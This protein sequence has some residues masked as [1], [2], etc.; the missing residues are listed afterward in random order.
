MDY[1][2]LLAD[3]D[4]EYGHQK[5]I[6]LG[7]AGDASQ[8]LPDAQREPVHSFWAAR[9]QRKKDRL[10]SE[11]SPRSFSKVATD[12]TNAVGRGGQLL[13]PVKQEERTKMEVAM[14]TVPLPPTPARP[15][16]C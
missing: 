4:Y 11:R 6:A 1:S 7:A 13:M 3:S 5:P 10:R 15:S 14:M 8:V 2:S 12:Y 16:S 9:A